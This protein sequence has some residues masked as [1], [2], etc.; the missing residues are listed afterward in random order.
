MHYMSQKKRNFRILNI[1]IDFVEIKFIIR[2]A[3]SF[4]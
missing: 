1:I 2:K 4:Q 3:G